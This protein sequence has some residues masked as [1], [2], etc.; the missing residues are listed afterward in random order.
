MLKLGNNEAESL[1]NGLR[2]ARQKAQKDA[3]AFDAVV[4]ELERLGRFLMHR[5]IGKRDG[6]NLGLGKYRP[7]ILELA[8]HSPFF[9]VLAASKRASH[10]SFVQ[11]YEEV[12][13]ARNS[14]MHGGPRARHATQH[15]IRLALV[16]EDALTKSCGESSL[17]ARDLMVRNPLCA[18]VWQPLSWIRQTMLENSFSSLP[19]NVGSATKR[20]WKL[21]CETAV[22]RFLQ[23][24]M[25]GRGS[26]LDESLGAAAKA[27]GCE[28]GHPG[29]YVRLLEKAAS[30]HPAAPLKEAMSKWTRQYA[31]PVLVTA[32]GAESAELLGILTPYD[33]L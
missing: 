22:A 27:E 6:G 25:D 11:S 10:V 21:V 20:A 28:D 2:D 31:L 1:R 9:C 14:Q 19:V 18:E 4:F 5:H 16:L 8:A 30:V 13:Q 23:H 15:A 33:L 29:N 7:F 32:D 17:T 12:L 26:L 3:E 24:R